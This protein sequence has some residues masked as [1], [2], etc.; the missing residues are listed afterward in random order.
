MAVGV[1]V[2]G[3]NPAMIAP[4][5][6]SLVAVNGPFLYDTVLPPTTKPAVPSKI[7]VPPIVT[8]G[9]PSVSAVPAISMPVGCMVKVWPL[10]IMTLE[11]R[12]DGRG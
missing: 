4:P 5:M 11:G 10:V 1:G 6:P 9:P 12:E 2:E 8:A 3:P 7:G